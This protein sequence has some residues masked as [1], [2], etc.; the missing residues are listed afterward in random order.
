MKAPLPD[1]EV[2]RIEKL[3]ACNILDTD[4]E[5]G[6]DEIAFLASH[7]CHTPVA[8]VSL[9]DTNRQWFKAKVGLAI[10]ETSRDIAFCAHTILKTDVLIIPDATKDG[11]F[12]DNPLVKEDPKIRFYAGAPLI[13]SEGYV[14]GTLCVIDYVPRQLAKTQITA[15]QALSRQVVV[16]LE[17]QL[18]L[19]ALKKE[20]QE[21]EQAKASEFQLRNL[22][23]QLEHLVQE[24]TAELQTAKD[25][26]EIRIQE[27]TAELTDSLHR[28]QHV[29]KEL[30]SRE[31]KLIYNASHDGLTGL[32]NRTYFLAS[33]HQAIH[34]S[35]RISAYQY[36]VI[37]IDLDSFKSINDSL[38]RDI[39]DKFIQHIVVYLKALLSSN[40]SLARLEGDEFVIL[41][42]GIQDLS[43]AIAFCERIQAQLKLPIRVDHHELLLGASIGIT[44]NESNQSSPEAV[45]R[46]ANIAM[47]QAKRSG[48]R[49]YSVFSAAMQTQAQKRLMLERDLHHAILRHELCLHYQ[50]ILSMTTQTLIGFEALV[51]WE[52]PQ[53]GLLYPGEFIQIAEETGLIHSLGRWVIQE[54]CEQ[55]QRWKQQFPDIFASDKLTMSVNLSAIQLR[56]PDLIKNIKAIL[57]ATGVS[58]DV[59]KL[60]LT[61]SC[62][63]EKFSQIT[64]TINALQNLGIQL[65]IDDFGTGYSSLSRLHEIPINTLKI[66]R[67]FIKNIEITSGKEA[68]FRTIVLLAHTLG[69]DVVAEGIE[70]SA[71]MQTLQSIGCEYGQGYFW[72]KPLGAT[73]I[74]T[75]FSQKQAIASPDKQFGL[76]TP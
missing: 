47:Y 40:D 14:L 8:L 69:M 34:K 71:Q 9:V 41:L 18:S 28:L 42:D 76:P 64:N 65:C 62:I 12:S 27:R 68:I 6:Y 55:M 1:N 15:L 75:L 21:R 29:Q 66:D 20:I 63:L 13:T 24:R 39:G 2:T 70:T 60:E 45:L 10:C 17:L 51:R 48:K 19:Q 67:S 53:Q 3:Y 58:R 16:Q 35:Q 23:Q 4:P 73:Q 74:D 49:C 72:Y 57:I 31:K 46:D 44:L 50:P 59:L 33:L 7:I 32:P 52:H 25:H 36:A 56:H 30:I 37:Y 22:N 43:Q 61:E 11:R 5:S 38:G 26:L 54:A